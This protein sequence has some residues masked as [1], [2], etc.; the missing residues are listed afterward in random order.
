MDAAAHSAPPAFSP[1]VR[2]Q[3]IALLGGEQIRLATPADAV[4]SVQP[5]LVVSPGT[6]D[7]LANVLRLANESEL[8][9]IPRGGGT[10]LDWGNPPSRADFILSAA[11][12]NRVLEHA[13][14]DMT[15]T[16]EAGCT[17]Q[18][19]QKTLALH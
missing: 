2:D 12:M 6:E 7:E 17:I 19:L 1:A 11:R 13:W 4:A 3:L 15:V 9:V 5:K 8:V 10:K 16:V 14:A 18:T